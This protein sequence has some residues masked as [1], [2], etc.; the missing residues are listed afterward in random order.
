MPAPHPLELVEVAL[1][2]RARCLGVVKVVNAAAHLQRF[3]PHPGE[4]Q[5]EGNLA[6]FVAPLREVFVESVDA[7]QVVAPE[8]H[9]AAPEMV[10]LA[11]VAPG[12]EVPQQA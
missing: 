6:V 4:V 2:P 12:Q 7:N 9:V 10:N 1:L 5:A 8:S 11:P 3:L